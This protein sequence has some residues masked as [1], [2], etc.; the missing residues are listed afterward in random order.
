MSA[1][2]ASTAAMASSRSSCGRP[3]TA[4]SMSECVAD[5]P[6][7]G[8]PEQPH[9][10]DRW[11][12]ALQSCGAAAGCRQGP[13]EPGC[14]GLLLTGQAFLPVTTV[15]GRYPHGV[16]LS[17]EGLRPGQGIGVPSC[18]SC[19]TNEFQ[20]EERADLPDLNLWLVVPWSG[21]IQHHR[22]RG[23]IQSVSQA[24]LPWLSAWG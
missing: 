18:W 20:A 12:A 13:L 14:T 10:I 19:S 1:A 23:L 3:S 5:I 7:H 22:A 11:P 4:R 17:G 15:G 24:S 16:R 8:R 2:A 6:L 9:T 21:L